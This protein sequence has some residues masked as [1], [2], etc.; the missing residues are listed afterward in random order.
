MQ[1]NLKYEK[2]A[3]DKTVEETVA[4]LKANNI[5]A[6]I[7]ETGNQA[8][9]KIL[10]MIPKKAEVMTMSSQTLEQTGIDEAINKS[11][12]YDAVKPKLWAMDRNTQARQMAKLGAAPDWV[13]GSV[14]AITK[15][16]KIVIASNTGSQLSAEAYA[17]GK[18]I[19]VVSTKKIVEDLDEAMKRIYEYSFPKE[20]ER[21]K[22]VYGMPS[23]VNKIL[24]INKEVFP[25]RTT[26]I[27][28]KEDL[29]Y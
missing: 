20:N 10:S 22:K 6:V 11:S 12:E 26:V 7:V 21:A 3:D 18:V 27:L 16:G 15:D 13:I 24:I 2:L 29:G 5:E 8:K 14:Q 4:S 19:F 23:G 28:V 1:P 17:G 9:E 25:G